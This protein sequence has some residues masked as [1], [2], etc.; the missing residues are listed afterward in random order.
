MAYMNE[1]EFDFVNRWNRIKPQDT[2][3]YSKDENGFVAVLL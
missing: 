2:K 3:T 1:V